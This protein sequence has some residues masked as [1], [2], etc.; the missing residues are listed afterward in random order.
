MKIHKLTYIS[1]ITAIYVVLCMIFEPI[2]FGVIQFRLSEIL[3]LLAID[4]PYAIIANTLGCLLSNMFLG[5]LGI[6]D[7][8]FGSLATFVSCVLAYLLRKRKYKN[9]PILSSLSI[10]LTNGLVIG[11]ELGI[12]TNN[13]HIIPLTILQVT[14]SEFIVVMLIGLPIYKKSGLLPP[15]N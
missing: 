15:L 4:S 11:I 8:L 14:L 2:S 1:I 7:T 5:G 12:I 3:C 13:L 9:M 10:V 6:I